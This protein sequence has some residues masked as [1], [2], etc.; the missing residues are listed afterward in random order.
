M[1]FA[2]TLSQVRALSPCS[3]R[4]QHAKTVLPARKK[5]TAAMAR[6]AGCTFDDLVW[7]ASTIAVARKAVERRIRHWMA[8]CAAH[9]LHLYE[10]DY[11]SDMR[12]RASIQAAR[13][14]ADGKID[15]AARAAAWD[16]AWA[17]TR[18]AARAAAREAARA[19]AW[20][21]AWD[22]AQTAAWDAA[23][24]AAR[25]AARAAAWDAAQAA[26]WAAEEKGQF[27]RL[28]LWLSEDEPEPFTDGRKALS[29]TPSAGLEF[30]G[31]QATGFNEKVRR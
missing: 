29:R 14:Y 30:S 16:A 27:D 8:D 5:I 3:E 17:A 21:A 23:R 25:A 13:D 26:A 18:D 9:V 10:R 4:W 12:V 2:L 19:A 11:P 15:A 28:I 22:A 7:L 24:S 1:T 20:A 6:E 31:R